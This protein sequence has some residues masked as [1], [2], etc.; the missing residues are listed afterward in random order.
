[1]RSLLIPFALL[2][3]TAAAAQMPPPDGGRGGPPTRA[4]AIAKAERRFAEMDTNHDGAVTRDEF[5]AYMQARMA[6]KF[7]G[8]MPHSS[9]RGSHGGMGDR[10]FD[11][12]DTNHDGRITLDEARAD[13]AQMFDRMDTNHDGMISPDERENGWRSRGDDTP[14]P[15]PPSDVP[16]P[17]QG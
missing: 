4:D 6:E 13:A 9:A 14:P 5:N 1:M 7:G 16:T 10:M 11:R 8:Q 17:P 2:T 15:P 3:A 12:F